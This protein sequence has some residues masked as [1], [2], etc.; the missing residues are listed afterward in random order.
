MTQAKP[1]PVRVGVVGTGWWATGKHLPS[2]ASYEAAQ[3]VAVADLDAER[4]KAVAT[5]FGVEHAFTDTADMFDH[6]ELDA[7]LVATPH[8]T[9]HRLGLAALE[10]GLHLFVEKPLALSG[11]DAWELVTEARRRELHLMVG[12]TYQFTSSAIRFHQ[13]VRDGV[14]GDLL[15]VAGIYTSYV[16]DFFHGRWAP[17]AESGPLASTYAD[18]ANQGGQGN[19]QAVHPLGMLLHVTGAVPVRAQAFMTNGDARVDVADAIAFEFAGGAVGSLGAIGTL[20]ADQP[21]VQTI[22]YVGTEAVAVQDLGSATIEIAPR[23]GGRLTLSAAEGERGYQAQVPSRAFVDLIAGNG[24]NHGPGEPA[25]HAS[26]LLEACYQS[27]ASGT[28]VAIP[29]HS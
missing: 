7:I 20:N 29:Q 3:V 6:A 15:A 16:N 4:A 25:A 5:Q 17:G 26:A 9:H 19:S 8:P 24:L 27:A 1:D 12:H 11:G 13:L 18:P 23:A 14:L 28:P 21:S 10:R 2:L 22:H